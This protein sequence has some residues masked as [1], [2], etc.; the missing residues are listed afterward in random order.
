MSHYIPVLSDQQLLAFN[1]RNTRYSG[2][3]CLQGTT[4]PH[5]LFTSHPCLSAGSITYLL[6]IQQHPAP[7]FPVSNLL[8][9]CRGRSWLVSLPSPLPHQR[10]RAAS[11][12]ESPG[13]LSQNPA[14][15]FLSPPGLTQLV[16][17]RWV[18]LTWSQGEGHSSSRPG[19]AAAG[20]PPRSWP[21]PSS[22]RGALFLSPAFSHPAPPRSRHSGQPLLCPC[23]SCL[24]PSRL[25]YL[26]VCIFL[27]AHS[28]WA[29]A[30]DKGQG[31]GCEVLSRPE[32]P[33]V[34]PASLWLCGLM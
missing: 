16:G 33:S 31:E 12:L 23:S 8:H 21:W 5:L 4:Q 32:C 28:P 24:I 26:V 14:P 7:G 18:S 6:G 25:L 15:G 1:R 30:R 3:S 19:A 22:S 10:F 9:R 13:A 11:P 29:P 27:T 20:L 17:S 2:W 34:R